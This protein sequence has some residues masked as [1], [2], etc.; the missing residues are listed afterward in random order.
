V[1]ACGGVSDALWHTRY[2]FE[3][4]TE[5]LYSP[6]HLVL[7]LGLVLIVTGPFRAGVDG[8][9]PVV[10][11]WRQ[12][13]LPFASLVLA[14]SIIAFFSPWGLFQTAW[15]RVPYDPSTG[16]GE[17]E[18]NAALCAELVTT[19]VLVGAMV[20]IVRRWRPPMGTCALLFATTAAMFN[21]VFDG[22]VLGVVAVFLG[23]VAADVILASR[24]DDLT[25]D[26]RVRVRVRT[27]AGAAAVTMVGG[28]HLLLFA[29]GALEWRAP[30]AAGTPVLAALAAVALTTVASP[31]HPVAPESVA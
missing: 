7:L 25:I 29:D 24:R 30:F 27:A 8:P 22:S 31:Q 26:Y 20:L 3:H 4:G 5:A 14:V 16:T 13:A 17:A 6:T 10:V 12:F 11:G 15:Y 2:G 18:L 21:L 1:F 19:I 9:S 23:G 28:W